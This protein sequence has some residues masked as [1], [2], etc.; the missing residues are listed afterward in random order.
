MKLR[1]TSGPCS[2]SGVVRRRGPR[3]KITVNSY[4]S[5]SA[6]G[7]AEVANSARRLSAP[8]AVFLQ[9]T[10]RSPTIRRRLLRIPIR[11][12]GAQLFG[13]GSLEHAR[14]IFDPSLSFSELGTNLCRTASRTVN[15]LSQT[16]LGGGL[17][18]D[19]TWSRYHLTAIYNGGETFIRGSQYSECASFTMLI[20]IQ[21]IDWARWRLLLRDDFIASPGAAFTGTGMG[22]PGLTAQILAPPWNLRSTA[23]DRDSFPGETIQTGNAMR[24]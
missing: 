7:S 2:R 14:N 23:S 10:I 6:H 1:E 13:V 12:S 9:P 4:I 22:G 15:L 20:V 21:E 19:R 3:S 5:A 16:L 24:Y 8:R 18:F 17:N 11:L